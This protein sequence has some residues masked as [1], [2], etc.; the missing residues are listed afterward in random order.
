MKSGRHR[1][2]ARTT[3]FQG[4]NSGSIPGER[5]GFLLYRRLYSGIITDCGSVEPGSIPGRRTRRCC[6]GV[7]NAVDC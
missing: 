5:K 4:V 3:L 2:M 6:G 7:V 1:L